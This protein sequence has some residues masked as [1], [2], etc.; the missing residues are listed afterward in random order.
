MPRNPR[1][2]LHASTLK[3]GEREQYAVIRSYG[4]VIV[5]IMWDPDELDRA[6]REGRMP[7]P[8]LTSITITK[9]GVVTRDDTYLSMLLDTARRKFSQLS[10]QHP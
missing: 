2:F 10:R 4:T 3:R 1:G 7:Q 8:W 5:Q 9:D 6:H